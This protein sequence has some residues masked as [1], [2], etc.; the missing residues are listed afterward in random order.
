[1]LINAGMAPCLDI[2]R[3]SRVRL[4]RRRPAPR[5]M[6]RVSPF[7][8]IFWAQPCVVTIKNRLEYGVS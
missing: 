4:E 5:R 1:M 7:L 8:K 2:L 6:S 3:I